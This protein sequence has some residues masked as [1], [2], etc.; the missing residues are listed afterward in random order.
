MVYSATYIKDK[1][2]L[3]GRSRIKDDLFM[4]DY[5][6]SGF[7][8]KANCGGN[9][10]ITFVAKN[11]PQGELGG[12]YFTVFLDGERLARDF[13]RITSNGKIEFVIAENLEEKEDKEN[14]NE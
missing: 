6:A 4:F 7:E 11:I 3:Q 2:K 9:I 12:C 13:C 8:F 14:E 10:K 5:S 1:I